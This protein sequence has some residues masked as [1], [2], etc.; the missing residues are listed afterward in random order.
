MFREVARKKQA[1]TKEQCIKILKSQLRGTLSVL[2][3]A[4]Y[5]YGLP[6]NHWYNED[7]GC[8][9]FHSGKVGHK[10]DAMKAYDKASFCVMDS[11]TK[12]EDDWALDFNSV[13]VFGRLEIIE[14][15]ERA[16]EMTRQLSYHFTDDHAYVDHEIE[17]DG[18]RTLCFR[19]KPEHITGKRVNEK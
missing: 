2:G 14:D 9:Y 17:K 6:M 8:L 15:H 19:L 5:P 1:L 10:I 12:A 11:G 18:S 3:D 16:L 7:D 13:I 4:G